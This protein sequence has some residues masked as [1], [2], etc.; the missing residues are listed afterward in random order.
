M[1]RGEYEDSRK[2]EI[3]SL[4]KQ[5]TADK[6]AIEEYRRRKDEP[7]KDVPHGSWESPIKSDI[8]TGAIDLQE[9]YLDRTPEG[10]SKF[11]VGSSDNRLF[12]CQSHHSNLGKVY[13]LE[14][15]EFDVCSYSPFK[16]ERQMKYDPW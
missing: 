9:I 13:W 10:K 14:R 11:V 15:I 3:E 6:E 5:L 2:K 8:A 7:L 12:Q 1:K 4:I 16:K